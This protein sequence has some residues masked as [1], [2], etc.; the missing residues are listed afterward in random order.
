MFSTTQLLVFVNLALKVTSAPTAVQHQYQST[1]TLPFA[2]SLNLNGSTLP[3]IDRARAEHAINHGRQIEE[4]IKSG[5]KQSISPQFEKRAA[6]FGVTNTAVSYITSIGV[7]NPP[8]NYNLLID[9]GSSITWIGANN[10]YVRTSTTVETGKKVSVHYG[11]GSMSGDQCM[12]SSNIILFYSLTHILTLI[13][14]LLIKTSTP[15][16]FNLVYLFITSQ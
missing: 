8:T 3:E 1:I 15:Y 6:S 16:H 7:G 9:T 4:A 10:G 13:H 11:S 12:L 2:L 14:P 5:T